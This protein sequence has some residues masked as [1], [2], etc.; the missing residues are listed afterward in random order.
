MGLFE[1][2]RAELAARRKPGAVRDWPVGKGT[3]L[4]FDPRY[5]HEDARFSPESYED[6]IATSNQIYSAATLRARLLSGLKLRLYRGEG[7]S[8]KDASSSPAASVLRYVNPHW[9]PSRLARMDELSMCLWGESYWAVERGPDGVPREI[10]WMKPSRVRPI[11]HEDSYLSGFL[12]EPIAGGQPIEFGA[13]EVVWFRYPNP[14]DEFSPLS[15]LAAARLAADTGND[16]MKANQALFTNGLA[17]G[18]LVVPTTDKVVFSPDQA[19]ELEELLQRRWSGSDKAHKWAVLRFEAQLKELGVTPKDAEY[20]GGL[21]LT[22]RQVANAYGIPSPLLNDMEFATLA[23]VRELLKALWTLTLV[24]DSQLRAEEIAE[25]FLPMFAGRGPDAAEYDYTRVP[26]LQEAASE[27]WARERQAIEIGR[28][29]IN[30]IREAN[31]EPSVAWGDVW[32][33]PVNKAPVSGPDGFDTAPAAEPE[34]APVDEPASDDDPAADPA[35]NA[36]AEEEAQ[37]LLLAAFG[38]TPTKANG[39]HRPSSL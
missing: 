14:I 3:M 6:Y 20:L 28:K 1:Q 10:W 12:Y 34:R 35:I 21:N 18:G 30:E 16:M 11:P 7:S 31:G 23:N 39:F 5:G 17:L 8:R 9:T 22:L 15:P 26:E 24:P 4:P 33:A 19:I 36:A 27:V 13:H 32:W 2:V 25:Q 29:T 37:R 38:R